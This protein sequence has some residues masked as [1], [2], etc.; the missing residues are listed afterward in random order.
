[1][2]AVNSTLI[3]N[4]LAIGCIVPGKKEYLKLC[5]SNSESRVQ[6]SFNGEENPERCTSRV[7]YTYSV[8]KATKLVYFG[9]YSTY[10]VPCLMYYQ[11]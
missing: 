7:R 9:E 11:E 4:G 3:I 1:M 2:N 10:L 5:N 8:L 6:G